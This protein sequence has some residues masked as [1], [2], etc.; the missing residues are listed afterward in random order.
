MGPGRPALIRRTA[1]VRLVA[2]PQ[3]VAQFVCRGLP[4]FPLS[5]RPSR[6][7][8]TRLRPRGLQAT[9]H[10]RTLHQR[11]QAVAGPGHTNRQTR[12]RPSGRAP[13]RQHPHLDP[14]LRGH[15]FSSAVGQAEGSCRRR[16]CRRSTIP[17]VLAAWTNHERGDT[18]AGQMPGLELRVRTNPEPCAILKVDDQHTPVA[19]VDRSDRLPV[20]R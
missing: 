5:A 15:I 7:P 3:G 20:E 8:P 11:P 19:H 17:A 2:Q 13:P 14:T 1:R 9:E 18:V 6:R 12:H 4:T 16:G 10:R